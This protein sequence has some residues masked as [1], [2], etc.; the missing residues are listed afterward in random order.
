[1]VIQG[2]LQSLKEKIGY[3]ANLTARTNSNDINPDKEQFIMLTN[4]V[5]AENKAMMQTLMGVLKS[6]G[7]KKD[8]PFDIEEFLSSKNF[9]VLEKKVD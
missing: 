8:L 9:Q 1:M 2:I 3:Y 4:S 5:Y 7:L 6:F